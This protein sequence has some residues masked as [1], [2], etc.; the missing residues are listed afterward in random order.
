MN[1]EGKKRTWKVFLYD[2]HIATIQS[3]LTTAAGVY[4]Y[5]VKKKLYNPDIRVTTGAFVQDTTSIHNQATKVIG[6][7][8][9][10]RYNY[11]GYAQMDRKTALEG[12]EHFK[13]FMMYDS[14]LR[15]GSEI[16]MKKEGPGYSL[17]HRSI[18]RQRPKDP[19]MLEEYLK[20][21]HLGKY[22]EK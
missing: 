16:V 5:L 1:K 21:N 19:K 14:M 4:R 7:N 10:H 22:A 8:T 6:G 13:R 15:Q 3:S 9:F 18:R 11:H 20:H 2:R 17:W 12:L